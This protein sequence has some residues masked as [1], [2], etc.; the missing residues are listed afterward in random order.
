VSESENVTI[1]VLNPEVV[2]AELAKV[3]S[4]SGVGVDEALTL[5]NQFAVYYNDIL[6][7]REQAATITDPENVT[8]QKLASTVRKGLK[9][10]RCDIERV[11]KNLKEES[12][13]KGKAID[14]FA[15]VLK[16]LCEPIEDK[17]LEIEKH[18]ERVEAARIAAM[19]SERTASLVAEG[20]DPAAYNL[21]Q[22]NDE[23]FALILSGAVKT[24]KD[25]EEAARLAEQQRIEREQADRIARE[26]AEAEAAA[27]RAEA[28]KERKAREAAEALARKEREAI[29]AKARAERDKAEAA[30][31][32]AKTEADAKLRAEREAREKAEAEAAA[33]RKAEADRIAAEK[34]RTAELAEAENKAREEF[35]RAEREAAEKAARA[36]DKEKLLAFADSFI[37]G[38]TAPDL[39]TEP[40]QRIFSAFAEAAGVAMDAMIDSARK[41]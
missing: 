38:L 34:R 22:M 11:R 2:G 41:L 40:A 17:L 37:A 39:Q 7:W 31:R 5:R 27:A 1:E 14:G 33:A 21:T 9:A 32:K 25:R 29:E 15:N 10:V 4:S 19:V 30:A 26:K 13:K 36:P 35:A 28:E 24:R 23:T 6:K 3:E 16:Y 8:H 20:A 12:L 18:A